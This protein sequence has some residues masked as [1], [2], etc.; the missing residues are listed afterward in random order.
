MPKNLPWSLR[1][2]RDGDIEELEP[3]IALSVRGLQGQHYSP[4]QREAA[5]GT[6]FGVDRQ[7]IRDGTY[8]VVEDQ[9]KIVGCG[10]WSWRK[11]IYGGEGHQL[12]QE[13]AL[14]PA[15]DAA[16]IRAFFVHPDWARRGIGRCLLDACENAIREAGFHRA[17]LVATLA[18]EPL[19]GACGYSVLSREEAPMPGG[20]TLPVVRMRKT[21]VEP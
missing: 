17:E 11:K 6:V 12:G 1:R 13:S 14:N 5:L 7:L 21:F 20:L 4:A 19:Y 2:A 3:L 10:G 15:E 16:R 18:G 9:G 8:W